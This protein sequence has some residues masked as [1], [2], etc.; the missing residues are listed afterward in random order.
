MLLGERTTGTICTLLE[1]VSY[2]YVLKEKPNFPNNIHT[3][4]DVSQQIPDS[5]HRLVRVRIVLDLKLE[6]V[7]IVSKLT[8]CRTHINDL[9]EN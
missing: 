4:K 9:P 5:N 1:H 7:E 2:E 6:R 8:A 3:I